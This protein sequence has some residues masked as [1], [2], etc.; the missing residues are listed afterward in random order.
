MKPRPQRERLRHA[1]DEEDVQRATPYPREKLAEHREPDVAVDR[2]YPSR[3]V[4]GH[5]QGAGHDLLPSRPLHRRR[6]VGLN[7]RGRC[8]EN[9]REEREEGRQAGT[10]RQEVRH[11]DPGAAGRRLRQHVRHRRLRA[12]GTVPPQCQEHGRRGHDLGQGR[13]IEDGAGRR[14]PGRALEDGTA[15]TKHHGRRAREDSGRDPL[16]EER[17][18]ARGPRHP[19]RFC[20]RAR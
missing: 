18:E 19:T 12:H 20:F 4:R 16:V 15:V 10:M 6:T 14:S 3:R 8:P 2:P 7:E 1:L 9:Q 13:Q 11:R 17:L 5:G